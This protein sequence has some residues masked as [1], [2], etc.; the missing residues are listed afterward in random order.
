MNWWTRNST[1]V[2]FILSLTLLTL[3]AIMVLMLGACGDYRPTPDGGTDTI[4]Q[5]LP[6]SHCGN[7]VCETG[8]NTSNCFWDC[9]DYTRF[10]GDGRCT[11]PESITSCFEDCRPYGYK[12][13][14]KFYWPWENEKPQVPNLPDIPGPIPPK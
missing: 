10:C 2:F 5:A 8:E 9:Y 1:G 12:E 3:V 7:N 11:P 6:S 4:N 13:D 14:K